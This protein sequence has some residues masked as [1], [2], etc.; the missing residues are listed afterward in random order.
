M[1]RIP[2]DEYERLQARAIKYVELMNAATSMP[3]DG[4]WQP[5]A[6]KLLKEYGTGVIDQP[7]NELPEDWFMR[8]LTLLREIASA[9]HSVRVSAERLELCQD[10]VNGIQKSLEVGRD[11]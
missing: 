10:L 11:A 2:I 8:M 4:G 7:G 1:I 6:A 3:V 9:P 5:I